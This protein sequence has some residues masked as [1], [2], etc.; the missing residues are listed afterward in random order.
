VKAAV[1]RL[2]SR[3]AMI[4]GGAEYVQNIRGVGY[5]MPDFPPAGD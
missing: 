2:R 5:V 3:L 4:D 1:Y